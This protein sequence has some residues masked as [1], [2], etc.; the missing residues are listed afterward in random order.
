MSRVPLAE[1]EAEALQ[2]V[3]A[4][5]SKAE[6]RE[7]VKNFQRTL[8]AWWQKATQVVGKKAREWRPDQCRSSAKARLHSENSGKLRGVKRENGI[9]LFSVVVR[10]WFHGWG[11]IT[12]QINKGPP[13]V[14][15]HE[16]WTISAFTGELLRICYLELKFYIILKNLGTFEKPLVGKKLRW[17]SSQANFVFSEH[18]HVLVQ[19]KRRGA[20]SRKG[21]V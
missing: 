3:W 11:F 10:A 9:D 8:T 7:T 6:R 21:C 15:K 16:I 12:N 20:E 14:C 17:F 19:W 1:N 5:I 18:R 2:V 4:S 13:E